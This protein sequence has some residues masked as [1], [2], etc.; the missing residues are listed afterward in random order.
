MGQVGLTGWRRQVARPAARAIAS[1]TGRS[2][3]EILALIGAGFLMMALIDFLRTVDDVLAA[4]R[5]GPARA[6]ERMRPRLAKQP[7]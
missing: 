7:A 3:P 2:E 4:G 6:D 1:R 5:A